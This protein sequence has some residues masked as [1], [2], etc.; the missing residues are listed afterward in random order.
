M[1]HTIKLI[2]TDFDGTLFNEKDAPPIPRILEDSIREFQGQGIKWIINTGRELGALLDKLEHANL[3]IQPDA[4]VV[5][6]RE[7]YFKNNDEY[8]PFEEWNNACR[9][10]CNELFSSANGRIL[11]FIDWIRRNFKDCLTYQ[12]AYSPLCLITG[13]NE[14]ADAIMARFN[15]FFS[16]FPQLELVRN[17][18]YMRFGHSKYT[19][20]TAL[21]TLARHWNAAPE[22]II[23]AG[24]HYNDLTMLDNKHARHLITPANAP[25]YVKKIVREQGGFITGQPFGCGIAE[26]LKHFSSHA[27]LSAQA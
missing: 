3:D 13:V 9:R 15:D 11:E 18:V 24:D 6:E 10:E 2:S 23:V 14:H 17:D 12:D 25:D 8:H 1:T 21:S 22:N 26:G 7:I 20:G 4:V 5:V 27:K 16:G 19:K